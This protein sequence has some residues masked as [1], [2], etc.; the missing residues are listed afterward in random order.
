MDDY[1]WIAIKDAL[2]VC[3]HYSQNAYILVHII[4]VFIYNK[5]MDDYVC[6]AIKDA[7]YVC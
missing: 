6:I 7:L 3:W 2:H 5:H 1:V 4:R